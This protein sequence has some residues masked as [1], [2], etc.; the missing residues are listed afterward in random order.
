MS[1]IAELM[2]NI[3]S[4]NSKEVAGYKWRGKKNY[5]DDSKLSNA[6]KFF[7]ATVNHSCH[8]PK[9]FE[10][11][12]ALQSI[13]NDE[14]FI[15]GFFLFHV[16]LIFLARVF[17]RDLSHLDLRVSPF[18]FVNVKKKL[19]EMLLLWTLYKTAFAYKWLNGAYGFFFSTDT[20]H[21][22]FLY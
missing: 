10:F 1:I 9:P 17:E 4:L 15:S 7:G 11:T 3:L 22:L 20:Y 13:S 16:G 19:A 18:V 5:V 12:L 21:V 2:N 14:R 6:F 8:V